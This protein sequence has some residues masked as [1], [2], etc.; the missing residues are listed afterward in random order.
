M[1]GRIKQSKSDVA[2]YMETMRTNDY[3][4]LAAGDGPRYNLPPGARPTVIRWLHAGKWDMDRLFWGYKPLWYKR[5]P[6]SNARLDTV[7]KGS[8]FLAWCVVTHKK[9]KMS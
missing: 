2:D 8:P 5:G 6:I 3:R 1:C 7:L 9:S 4:I